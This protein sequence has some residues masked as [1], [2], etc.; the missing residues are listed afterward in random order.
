LVIFRDF[1]DFFGNWKFLVIFLVISLKVSNILV[2]TW[3]STKYTIMTQPVNNYSKIQWEQLHVHACKAV[4]PNC[5]LLGQA[6]QLN[7]GNPADHHSPCADC[8]LGTRG[9]GP[10]IAASYL[11]F[12]QLQPKS[13]SEKEKHRKNIVSVMESVLLILFCWDVLLIFR[14]LWLTVG[15]QQ[16]FSN[17]F[18]VL[19]IFS[20]L[21]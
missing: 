7:W 1:S 18:Y 6:V 21:I 9:P 12:A 11:H 3:N 13:T 14:P 8:V 19:V 4:H 16:K 17:F 2:I 15:W 5:K 10:I 20:M